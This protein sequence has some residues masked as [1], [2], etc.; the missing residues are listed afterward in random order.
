MYTYKTY[1]LFI[2]LTIISCTP[3]FVQKTNLDSTSIPLDR[4]LQ[5]PS[6][7]EVETVVAPARSLSNLVSIKK[8][9]CYG[10]CPVFELKFFSNNYVFWRGYD[11]VERMGYFEAPIE[12]KTFKEIQE[13]AKKI[14]IPNM[15][16]K[17]PQVGEYL[18][19]YPVTIIRVGDGNYEKR[20]IDVYDA[21][22]ALKEFESY[23]LSIAEK[24]MWTPIDEI[25]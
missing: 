23:L 7:V 6:V 24:L 8:T 12:S 11:N 14:G 19:D 15:Q 4:L 1:L 22:L 17:Y 25:D 18:D 16:N 13:K 3:K 21:P 10:S 2:C 20:I 9:P 5:T